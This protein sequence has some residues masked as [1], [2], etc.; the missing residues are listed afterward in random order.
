MRK[1]IT[2]VV[3]LLSAAPAFA[4]PVNNVPEPESLT[5]LAIGV[6]AIALGKVVKK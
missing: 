6:V 3:F 2:S 4:V 5:L 1:L